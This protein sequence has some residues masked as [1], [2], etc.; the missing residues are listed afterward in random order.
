MGLDYVIHYKKR[1]ENQ[2]AD[3]L[4]RWGFEEE[5]VQ[6][7]TAV[8]PTQSLKISNSYEGDQ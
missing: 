5:K 7:I 1:K 8:I 2:A 3:V 4:S 6:A